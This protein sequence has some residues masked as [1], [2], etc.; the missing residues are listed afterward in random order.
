MVEIR[1]SKDSK[2]ILEYANAAIKHCLYI[3]GWSIFRILK[4]VVQWNG[5]VNP[6]TIA[7]AY[8][9]DNIPV[10]ICILR[11]GKLDTFVRKSFRKKGIGKALV[12]SLVKPQDNPPVVFRGIKGSDIFYRKCFRKENGTHVM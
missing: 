10:G 2:D 9:C 7:L 11:A 8:T 1:V 12:N 6:P 3:N 4:N 5:V